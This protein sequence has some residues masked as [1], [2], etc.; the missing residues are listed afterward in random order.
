MRDTRYALSDAYCYLLLKGLNKDEFDKLILGM[1][2]EADL[3]S[4]RLCLRTISG[5]ELPINKLPDIETMI[6]EKCDLIM[7]KS[8]ARFLDYLSVSDIMCLDEA[9]LK[10]MRG[11]LM[12]DV[13]V[14]DSLEEVFQGVPGGEHSIAIIK[15]DKALRNFFREAMEELE[16]GRQ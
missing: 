9:F 5:E 12:K 7:S 3:I 15:E 10:A 6:C 4:L 13:R 11:E 2:A 16:I 8:N 1:L 14:W